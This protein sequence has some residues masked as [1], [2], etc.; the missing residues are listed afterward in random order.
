MAKTI[1]V[2]KPARAPVT[3]RTKVLFVTSEM[4]PWIK[5]GGLADVAAGL[6]AALKALGHDVRVLLPAYGDIL[7]Q[8]HAFRAV[9]GF[10]APEPEEVSLITPAKSDGGPKVWLLKA[11][12][13]SDRRGNPY[14][15]GGG[16]DWP[17]NASR[18]NTLAK[19]AADIAGN[20][21]GLKWQP[22]VIHCNDWQTGLT[23][24][25]MFLRRINVPVVFTIHNLHYRGLFP[26]SCLETLHLPS[27]LDHADALEFYGNISFIKGGLVFADLLNTVSPTYA[28]EIQSPEMGHGLDGLLAHRSNDLSGI[29]NGIDH[30]LW[31]PQQ[32]PLLTTTYDVDHLEGKAIAKTDLQREVGLEPRTDIPLV[33]LI[34]R[35]VP[36]KGIDILIEALPGI[37]DFPA[38]M[39]VLGSGEAHMEWLLNE[40]AQRYP[41]RLAVRV[42]FDEGLAHRIEAGTDMFLMPS[43]FE[44]CGL[45]QL[46]S[47]RYGTLPIVHRCGGLADSVINTNPT[48]LESGHATGFVFDEPSPGA[49]YHAVERAVGLYRQPEIWRGIV[50]NA[51][52]QD[53]GWSR[54]AQEYV[55]YYRRAADKLRQ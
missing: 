34:A 33:G 32:D 24:V 17:D 29:L 39:V 37:M 19:I 30:D 46:Y 45:N 55:A 8:D 52:Q 5:T 21:A 15:D 49:L 3:Q 11:P 7:A 23:P 25:W 6:P 4:H 13:F 35:L 44:P 40:A 31:N 2:K 18:F 9:P 36:Q 42:G 27:W 12:G 22:D 48:T 50:R 51:M 53:F 14:H 26:R 38:Q 28:A 54:S 41:G 16:N 10:R 1:A 20:R 43:R 47:L